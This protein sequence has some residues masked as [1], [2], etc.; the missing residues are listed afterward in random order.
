M[1]ANS[2]K[3]LLDANGIMERIPHRFPMLMID[4][5]I[6][7]VPGESATALKHVT[8][9]EPFFAGHF[10]GHP[11]MPGVLIVEAMAQTSAVLVVDGLNHAS[12]EPKVKV[13]E[14]RHVVYFMTIHEARFRRPVLPGCVLRIV[15]TKQR[16][17]GNV[18]K[19]HGEAWVGSEKAAD[20]SYSAMLIDTKNGS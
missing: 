11:I 5:I 4:S 6:E 8:G 1:D 16:Q 15:V 7:I 12:P 3:P 13:E 19:F 17:R 18:W 20:A 2:P 9:Q 10:P 14:N